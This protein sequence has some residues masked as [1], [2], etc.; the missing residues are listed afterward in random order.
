MLPA[1]LTFGTAIIVGLLGSS[2][3]IGMC[4]GIVAA[5]NMG[6]ADGAGRK[7]GSLFVYQLS[8][9]AGRITSYLLVGLLAGS[10]G[11]GLSQLGI[12]PVAGKLLAAA[13][14][15]ALG[16]YL[17]NWWRGLALLERL[18][19]KLWRH[20]QPLGKRL[21]PIRNPPQAYLLGLI[22]GWLP[23]GLVYAVVAW[24]LTT[25]NALDGAKLMLG[26]GIGTL[27]PLLI[28]GNVLNH[29]KNRVRSPLFR[30]S[31]GVMII[32]FG[33]YSGFSGLTGH[34]HHRV[35]DLNSTILPPLSGFELTRTPPILRS[36]S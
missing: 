23:C 25:A 6:I 5:L 14:M 28:A 8:Y 1:D 21:F 4:G 17:A 22:W 20:I 35:T 3:C 12:S 9:N 15:I 18:G 30:T 33:L 24:S 19:F 31:A 34:Y 26:F 32:A 11:A 10:L 7:P 16:L 13:F 36:V 27:P 29:F 2:H